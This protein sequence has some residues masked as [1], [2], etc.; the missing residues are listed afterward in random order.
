MKK[1]IYFSIIGLVLIAFSLVLGFVL[2]GLDGFVIASGTPLT[3]FW[4][5]KGITLAALLGILVYIVFK[6]Q[7]AGNIYIMLKYTLALQVLPFVER[8]LLKGDNPHTV[9]AVILLFVVFIAYLGLFFAT[10]ILADKINAKEPELQGKSIEVVE[11][12]SF[13]D[14][15]G[16]FKGSQK[17]N[18]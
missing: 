11:D 2:D 9:W 8:L 17:D 15:N 13:F 1:Y 16:K 7:D 12:E 18:S 10:D 6:K 4:V 5:A 14:E 3:L